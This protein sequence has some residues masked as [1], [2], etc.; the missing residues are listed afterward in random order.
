MEYAVFLNIKPYTEKDISEVVQFNL[1]LR[2]GG[3]RFQFPVSYISSWLPKINDRRIYQEFYLAMESER[4]RG[5]YI[6][7]HQDFLI[8]GETISVGDFQLPLSEGLIDHEFTTVGIMMFVDA[9]KRQPLLYGL[10]IGSSDEP[11]AKIFK[12][13]GWSFYFIPF[14]FKVNHPF[15]FL[16]NISYLRKNYFNRLLIDLLAITA[17]GGIIIKSYQFV[18]KDRSSKQITCSVETVSNFSTWADKLWDTCK[19]KYCFAAVR[20]AETLNILY[21]MSNNRFIRL[22]VSDNDGVIG[23]TV[24]LDTFMA[25]HKQFGNM[26][27]G[28]IVDSFALP[29]EAAKV[30][31][32]ATRFLEKRGVDLIISN[33]CHSSWALALK[34]A[35]FIQGPSNYI[36]AA[37]KALSS[38]LQ[39]WDMI[40]RNSHINRGDGD[41]PINL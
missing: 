30:I 21:P 14:Y 3:I 28:S 16:R 2:K 6:L 35:G 40:M 41:G 26:R 25:N 39:P 20:D 8:N 11:I 10:G 5:A 18:I 29:E 13:M 7:K 1:R 17:I 33:Q 9:L 27:V 12:A 37:S 19:D 34:K 23:W 4:V 22:K 31:A 24:V 36:F 15:R 32:C 38:L